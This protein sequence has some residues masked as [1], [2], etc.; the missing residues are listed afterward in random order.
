MSTAEMSFTPTLP[1]EH[2]E[3]DVEGILFDMD[4]TLVDSIKAVE[5]AWGAVAAEI[6]EDPE[7]VIAATHGRRAIDNLKDLKPHLRRLTNEQMEPHV[8]EFEKK[9]LREADEFS[10]KVRSRRASDASSRRNSTSSSRRPSRRS[11]SS[12][13]ANPLL[14][15]LAGGQFGMSKMTTKE[16]TPQSGN[17]PKDGNDATNLESINDRLANLDVSSADRMAQLEADPFEDDSDEESD[18]DL[19]EYTE[20]E[21]G[22]RNK[23]VRILPGVRRLID[24][25]PSGRFAVATSGAKTYCHGALARA[26]IKRPKVTIT[27]D[28]PRLTAGKPDPAPFILA[29][30]EL[31][32]PI[33]KCLVFEDSP[34]G[35]KAG[36]ASGART[37]A[38]CTSHPV[39]KINT[40]GA[41]YIVPSLDCVHARKNKDGSIRITIDAHP[42]DHPRHGSR[43]SFVSVAPNW[44]EIQNEQRAKKLAAINAAG[45]KGNSSMLGGSAKAQA[46]SEAAQQQASA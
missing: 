10:E 34:S 45:D 38:I 5:A 14:S 43:G 8:E 21:I 24:S 6:G 26:G 31:G 28:D 16:P 4:G 27:A 39:E 37:I 9:I 33:E 32:I 19:D 7:K 29:A 22:C 13:G 23:S 3:F 2:A 41:H 17:T 20:E 36:V 18:F 44:R 40:Q 46:K 42:P 35:I 1:V 25:L 11:S 30:K 15:G 12:S